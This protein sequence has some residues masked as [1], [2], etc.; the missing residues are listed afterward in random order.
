EET[1]KTISDLNEEQA[2]H[3]KILKTI[4]DDKEQLETE[5]E[6]AQSQQ[7]D[8][9]QKLMRKYEMLMRMMD[10]SNDKLREAGVDETGLSQADV[11][12]LD[13]PKQILAASL[14][15]ASSPVSSCSTSAAAAAGR[16]AAVSSPSTPTPIQLP[17]HPL[18]AQFPQLFPQQSQSP[19]QLFNQ[20]QNLQQGYG[21]PALNQMM[22]N[23]AAL[24]GAL[25][26]PTQRAAASSSS[27]HSSPP[28]KR[29]QMCNE[30]IHRNAPI[31]PL[32]K[33]KSRSKNPKKPKRKE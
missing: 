1:M 23:A 11:D 24:S 3:S 20:M 5:V 22:A 27:D 7:R 30:L 31:C 21:F 15:A 16:S 4:K 32:C 13:I 12:A 29:C 25:K 6:T 28:M 14:A 19:L 26:T 9:E 8:L 17:P 33:C 18:L 2:E 10:Q